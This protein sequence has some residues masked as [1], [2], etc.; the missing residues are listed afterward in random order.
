LIG[1]LLIQWMVTFEDVAVYFTQSQW[2]SLQPAHNRV[3]TDMMMEN[4]GHRC[5]L[6]DSGNSR[7]LGVGCL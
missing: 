1:S 6:R 5:L 2:N 7:D 3:C 4:Y